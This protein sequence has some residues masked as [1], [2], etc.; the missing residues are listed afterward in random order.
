MKLPLQN[1][2]EEMRVILYCDL[3]CNKSFIAMGKHLF[4]TLY[5]V[6]PLGKELTRGDLVEGT[7]RVRPLL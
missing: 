7:D 2:N 4:I 5:L 3:W 6:L 1:S